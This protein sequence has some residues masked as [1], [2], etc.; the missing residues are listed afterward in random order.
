MTLLVILPPPLRSLFFLTATTLSLNLNAYCTYVDSSAGDAF[1]VVWKLP[2]VSSS[3]A[4]PDPETTKWTST[5][6]QLEPEGQVGIL[7]SNL[8]GNRAGRSSLLQERQPEE[9]LATRTVVDV[10]GVESDSDLRV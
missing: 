7:E 1:L 2:A 9:S 6:W 10:T 5:N 3:S 8:N 4:R